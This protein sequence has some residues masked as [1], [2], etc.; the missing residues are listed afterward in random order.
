MNPF[1][2][3]HECRQERLEQLE[4]CPCADLEGH[5]ENCP[6]PMGHPSV[7]QMGEQPPARRQVAIAQAEMFNDVVSMD[8]NFRT[9]KE[10]N[11]R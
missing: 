11:R 5:R 6:G 3:S 4:R 7:Q 2:R 1:W 9:L 10:R 8:V